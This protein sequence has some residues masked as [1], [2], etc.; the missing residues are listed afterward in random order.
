[1]DLGAWP[2]RLVIDALLTFLT[3]IDVLQP[4][5]ILRAV[6]AL[7]ENCA[8]GDVL[9]AIL[10]DHVV[11]SRG[12][13]KLHLRIVLNHGVAATPVASSV[14]KCVELAYNYDVR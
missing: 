11:A 6:D 14:M 5:N 10:C 4:Q 2:V 9:A 8:V 7:S 3:A 1:M 12:R 13:E